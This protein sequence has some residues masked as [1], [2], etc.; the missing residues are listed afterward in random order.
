MRQALL[1]GL[2]PQQGLLQAFGSAEEPIS[3]AGVCSGDHELG[4]KRQSS[5]S[6]KGDPYVRRLLFEAAHVASRTHLAWLAEKFKAL[7]VRRGRKWAIVARAHTLLKTIFVLI[8]RDDYCRDASVDC[9]AMNMEHN[10]PR[11]IRMLRKY[12]RFPA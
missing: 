6:R 1:A 7:P 8:D 10:A 9:E 3:W 5:K 11:L 12:G 2:A 4:G